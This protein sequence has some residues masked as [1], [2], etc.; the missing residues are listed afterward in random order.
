MRLILSHTVSV[1]L[2]FSSLWFFAR[3]SRVSTAVLRLLDA[4]ETVSQLRVP[5][6]RHTGSISKDFALNVKRTSFTDLDNTA[7]TS[8]RLAN[9]SKNGGN[10][11][12][13]VDN[14]A[15]DG[16]RSFE[17]TNFTGL[18]ID[19]RG[20]RGKLK[21]AKSRSRFRYATRNVLPTRSQHRL[22][23]WQGQRPAIWLVNHVYRPPS[24]SSFFLSHSVSF[25]S[26][27]FLLACI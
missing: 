16:F 4:R 20:R 10:I 5:S 17:R 13:S 7:V 11:L 3:S 8:R 24:H 22:R 9:R 14:L 18:P 26:P 27:C 21:T 12:S 2:L 15:V 1:R 25:S 19:R 6:I 23:S